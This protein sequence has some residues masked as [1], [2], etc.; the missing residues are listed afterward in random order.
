MADVRGMGDCRG[1]LVT[2][3]R[4]LAVKKRRDTWQGLTEAAKA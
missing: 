4:S 3:W 2:L 1:L